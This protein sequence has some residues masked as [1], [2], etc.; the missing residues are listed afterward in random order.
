MTTPTPASRAVRKLVDPGNNQSCKF[1]GEYIKFMARIQVKQI[2]ANVYEDGKWLR[3]DYFH[4]ECYDKA[5]Q[6]FGEP[7]NQ[8]MTKRS[9]T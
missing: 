5:G 8:I 9:T 6:P 3:I 7:D 1:C 2:I 4:D